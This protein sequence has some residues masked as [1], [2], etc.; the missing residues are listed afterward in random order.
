MSPIRA[1]TAGPTRKTKWIEPSPIAIVKE[2]TSLFLTKVEHKKGNE[3]GKAWIEIFQW[4][5]KVGTTISEALDI[6]LG[7]V[8]GKRNAM[9]FYLDLAIPSFR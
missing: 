4:D 6:V 7:Q 5:P 8:I 1:V 9:S 2:D 3:R